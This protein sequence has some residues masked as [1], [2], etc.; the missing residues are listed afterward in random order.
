MNTAIC[1]QKLFTICAILSGTS[2]RRNTTF[3]NVQQETTPLDTNVAQ[4]T[5]IP[6][7]A[8]IEHI[9]VLTSTQQ[10]YSRRPPFK[11]LKKKIKRNKR[12]EA[13]P[14]FSASELGKP[15][16]RTS[17]REE[18]RQGRPWDGSH[19]LGPARA[20]K[21]VKQNQ[22]K[23]KQATEGGSKDQSWARPHTGGRGQ[24]EKY[25]KKGATANHNLPDSPQIPTSPR[26]HASKMQGH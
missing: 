6:T 13:R 1:L 7:R 20:S 21:P 19:Q 9:H 22:Q 16:T 14:N 11:N 15:G 24:T 10:N 23:K 26:V 18:W 25:D 12:I 17:K 8:H 4:V 5:H 2:H 3:Q